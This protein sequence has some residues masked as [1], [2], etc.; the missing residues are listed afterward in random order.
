MKRTLFP[1]SLKCALAFAFCSLCIFLYSLQGPLVGGDALQAAEDDCCY[2]CGSIEAC[3]YGTDDF[4]EGYR[5]C[6][7]NWEESPP[8]EVQGDLC[9]CD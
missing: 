2:N 3:K 1:T 9:D 7:I 5:V 6:K 4:F 8:C